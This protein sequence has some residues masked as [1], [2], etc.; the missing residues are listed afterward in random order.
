MSVW[1]RAGLHGYAQAMTSKE[2]IST[3]RSWPTSKIRDLAQG[4]IK[5]AKEAF[6]KASGVAWYEG[7]Y[8]RYSNHV[9]WAPTSK[10]IDDAEEVGLVRLL[11]CPPPDCPQVVAQVG[12]TGGLDAA[13]YSFLGHSRLLQIMF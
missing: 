7:L 6:T 11:G 5:L 10:Q 4:Q 12:V 8:V 2:E 9:R 13:E 3:V 1:Y